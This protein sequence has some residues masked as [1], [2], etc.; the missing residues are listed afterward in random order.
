MSGVQ[1][2]LP[3][4]FHSPPGVVALLAP[5][6]VSFCFGF[7]PPAE[8]S[9]ERSLALRA[10]DCASLVWGGA[11]LAGWVF[12]L[13]VLFFSLQSSA[14]YLGAF[15]GR[16]AMIVLAESAFSLFLASCVRALSWI[17]FCAHRKCD[18]GSSGFLL[19]SLLLLFFF[20]FFFYSLSSRN[21][22]FS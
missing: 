22:F 6:F 1:F 18:H 7:R 16:T 12:G 21:F 4:P 17:E 13:V 10:G 19:L 8:C 3:L 15:L 20:F 5:H 14:L 2:P 9:R 11:A